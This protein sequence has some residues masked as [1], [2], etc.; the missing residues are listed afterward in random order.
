M[1]LRHVRPFGAIP[2]EMF[3]FVKNTELVRIPP[4]MIR[5]GIS[6]SLISTSTVHS[7][8]FFQKL[9]EK[10]SVARTRSMQSE[11]LIYSGLKLTTF[12]SS[13]LFVFFSRGRLYFCVRSTPLAGKWTEELEKKL[14]EL[15]RQRL[16]RHN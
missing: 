14:N 16:V 11:I 4:Y 1:Q 2:P 6:S 10:W 3:T 15:G 7:T 8:S 13:S 9:P 5:P 12:E